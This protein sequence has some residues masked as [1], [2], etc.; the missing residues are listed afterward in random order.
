[1][2]SLAQGSRAAAPRSSPR[3]DPPGPGRADVGA[4]PGRARGASRSLHGGRPAGV[5]G[6]PRA[7]VPDR[8]AEPSHDHEEGTLQEATA[9]TPGRV[10]AALSR[11]AGFLALS[12]IVENKPSRLDR[13]DILG[14]LAALLLD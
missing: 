7:A 2:V 13:L 4:R 3:G 6:G 5:S 8:G 14:E 10:G 12:R 11:N 1:M 9:I